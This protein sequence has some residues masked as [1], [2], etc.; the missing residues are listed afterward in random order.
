MSDDIVCT[1]LLTSVKLFPLQTCLKYFYI[2]L[3]PYL[4]LVH[5]ASGLMHWAARFLESS[6]KYFKQQYTKICA[7][8]FIC[9]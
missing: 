1:D 6:I 8:W 9:L 4:T 2:R 5:P 3:L 7:V